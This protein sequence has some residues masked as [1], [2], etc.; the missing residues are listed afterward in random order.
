[1]AEKVLYFPYI[2]VPKSAWFTRILLYWDEVGAIV[3]Y[4]Y[5]EEP[6]RLGPYAGDLVRANLVTQVIPGAHIW[7]VDDFSKSFLSYLESLGPALNARRES[8]RDT[9]KGSRIHVEKMAELT[10]H[11]EDLH[12]AERRDYPWFQVE[13][14]TARDF[15]GYLAAVLGRQPELGFIPI[16]DNPVHLSEFIDASSL[17]KPTERLEKLRIDVL[18]DLL[19]S[20]RRPLTAREIEEFKRKH[21]KLLSRFRR[22]VEKELIAIADINDDDLRA[23][24]LKIFRQETSEE[25]K[26]VRARMS[27]SGWLDMI[28]GKFSAIAGAIP[29][30]PWVV[31]LAHA[32]HQALKGDSATAGSQPLLYAAYA[33]EELLDS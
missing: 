13:A 4:D 12:L 3:P 30:A 24:R 28:L 22:A 6:E 29:G 20:P 7:Q 8:F 16:T 26:E 18:E 14:N 31:G 23:Q 1:M 17:G 27:E 10:R 32:V 11:L 33:Q 25:L 5:V 19:P 15:M 21:G 9:Q 2:Q